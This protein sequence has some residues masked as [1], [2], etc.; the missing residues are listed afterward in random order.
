MNFYFFSDNRSG[1]SR[2]FG[3]AVAAT[4]EPIKPPVEV[5]HT[6]LL[7]NGK[8]VDSASGIISL[9]AIFSINKKFMRIFCFFFR[10]DFSYSGSKNRG[11]YSS[12]S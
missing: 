5:K 12:C 9:I 4:E 2:L 1:I 3:T 7:I 11:G 6:Q 8:F 10:E